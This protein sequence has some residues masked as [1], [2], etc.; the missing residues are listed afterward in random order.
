MCTIIA[1]RQ[2]LCSNR[3][4]RLTG[5]L[6]ILMITNRVS[7]DR[8]EIHS[9]NTFFFISFAKYLLPVNKMFFIVFTFSNFC[10]YYTS[11]FAYFHDF[12]H[13]IFN[14]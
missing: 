12:I 3:D 11:L 5:P 6:P 9:I 1:C 4:C 10:F 8:L 13:L 14:N 2:S 7:V